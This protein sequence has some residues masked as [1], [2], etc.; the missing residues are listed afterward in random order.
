ML[1]STDWPI[2]SSDIYLQWTEHVSGAIRSTGD[3]L[4]APVDASIIQG[5]IFTVTHSWSNKL[6]FPYPPYGDSC[7]I[8]TFYPFI[9]PMC[10]KISSPLAP[11]FPMSKSV[12][13]PS[14]WPWPPILDSLWS[15]R[16]I[17]SRTCLAPK[18][19]WHSTT[20]VF[21]RFLRKVLNFILHSLQ[22][23]SIE[24][25]NDFFWVFDQ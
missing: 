13:M 1:L 2:E 22:L 23:R 10:C 19:F 5:F 8:K 15:M 12:W 4:E 18:Q 24:F 20:W 14:P 25:Y 17:S 7:I 3:C 16:N 11:F 21:V 6:S 9:P